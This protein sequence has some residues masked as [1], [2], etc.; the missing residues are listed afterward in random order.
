MKSL[1]TVLLASVLLAPVPSRAREPSTFEVDLE[2]RERSLDQADP[3]YTYHPIG[4]RDPFKT[5]GEGLG[6]KPPPRFCGPLCNH[7]LSQLKLVALVFSIA[8]PRALIET[9]DGK[10]IVVR[11][12]MPIGRHGGR[13]S[14]IDKTGIVVS[15]TYRDGSG[16]RVINKTPMPLWTDKRDR[17]ARRR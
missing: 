1:F 13:I 9:P 8:S 7:D 14:S 2:V 16:R 6:P 11:T 4:K 5:Y 3:F 17:P 10:G 15:E 12:G